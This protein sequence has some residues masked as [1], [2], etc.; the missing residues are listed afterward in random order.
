VARTVTRPALVL[1]SHGT[2][3]PAGQAAV[4]AL[5]AA[6]RARLDDVEVRETWV[7]VQQPQ[8]E[9]VV[10]TALAEGFSPVTIVPL[11]LSGGYH[12]HV[13]VARAASADSVRAT[14][15]LG[16][17]PRLA[18]LLVRRLRE[19]GADD[20]DAVVV[21]AAGSSDERAVADVEA[22]VDV[23][24]AG[25]DGPVSVGYGSKATPTVPAAVAA[26]R[27]DH[28][29]RRVVVAGYLLAP[30]FFHDRLTAAGGDL[31]TEP[32]LPVRDGVPVVDERLVA[33]VR[34][35]FHDGS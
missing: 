33:L 1:C 26:A 3:D 18:E 16:P 24:R 2:A 13:D 35:R 5:V 22:V 4:S 30:G 23:V 31:V 20:G 25:W 28:P 10:G 29:G 6:V 15:A 8:V 12:V 9:E 34:D 7:D 27:A 11:L 19:A 14:G 21:A 17:D 32:L